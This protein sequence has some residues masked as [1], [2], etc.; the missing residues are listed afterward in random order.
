M[1]SIYH[2]LVEEEG[3]CL[4]VHRCGQAGNMALMRKQ[5]GVGGRDG[6]RE[7]WIMTCGCVEMRLVMV[8]VEVEVDEVEVDMK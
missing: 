4:E 3:R 1:T 8:V 6:G 7:T 2:V 5:C